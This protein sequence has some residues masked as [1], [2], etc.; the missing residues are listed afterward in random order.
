[1]ELTQPSFIVINDLKISSLDQEYTVEDSRVHFSVKNPELAIPKII[2]ELS[3]KDIAIY[4][5][6]TETSSLEDVF[7][8]LTGKGINAWKL[9][10]GHNELGWSFYSNFPWSRKVFFCLSTNSNSWPYLINFIYFGVKLQQK[11]TKEGIGTNMG[12]GLLISFSY[13]LFF[14]F[15]STLSTNGD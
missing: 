1:M 3:S 2:Q 6:K 4:S 9:K 7:L 13:I 14:Q 5:I 8:S 12:L 15:S 10:R 11:K